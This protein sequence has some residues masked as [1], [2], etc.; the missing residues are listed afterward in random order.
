MMKEIDGGRGGG[1]CWCF[2]DGDDNGYADDDCNGNVNDDD[3]LLFA[4]WKQRDD[5]SDYIF[6]FYIQW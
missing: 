2:C 3:W 6:S 1:C 4:S 5:S